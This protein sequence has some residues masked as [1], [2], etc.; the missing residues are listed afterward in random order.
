MIIEAQVHLVYY[1]GDEFCFICFGM[2]A[3]RCKL[4]QGKCIWRYV[5]QRELKHV[6]EERQK[7]EHKKRDNRHMYERVITHNFGILSLSQ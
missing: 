4:F 5:L 7:I 6:F 2:G 3:Y 1:L